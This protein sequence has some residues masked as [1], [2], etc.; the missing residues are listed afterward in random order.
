M[1]SPLL[2][3]RAGMV[4][5]PSGDLVLNALSLDGN[6]GTLQTSKTLDLKGNVLS[7]NH[8]LSQADY[9]LIEAD[10]LKH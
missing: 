2:F 6:R 9:I 7:L 3:N 8:A 5:V 1:D 10:S 4:T